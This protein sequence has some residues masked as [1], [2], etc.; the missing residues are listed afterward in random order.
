MTKREKEDRARMIKR[1]GAIGFTPDE[2]Q[3][4]RRISM[5]LRRWF[6]LECGTENSAGHSVSVQR[7]ESSGYVELRIAGHFGPYK[8]Y[9]VS[10]CPT[11]DRE[12][13][14]RKRLGSI[15]G[16]HKRRATVYVQTDPR[17]CALYVVSFVAWR[18]LGKPAMDTC[19]SSVGIAVY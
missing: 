19:Y 10:Y 2:C 5:T 12:A 18:K 13:A 6:E 14:A 1:L 17:G 8:Q 11:S 9:Q 7:D 15:M 4:L 16:K 3:Q